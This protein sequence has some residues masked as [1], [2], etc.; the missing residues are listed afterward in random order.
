MTKWTADL[1][2]QVFPLI[3]GIPLPLAQRNRIRQIWTDFFSWADLNE[4]P[5]FNR[6][7]CSKY[8]RNLG[9][10]NKFHF[11]KKWINNLLY[12]ERHK[13]FSLQP[14]NLSD[15]DEN[16]LFP[17]VEEFLISL[18][19]KLAP[20]TIYSYR[21][22]LR[23]FNSFLKEHN[24]DILD[25]NQK[26]IEKYHNES[27]LGEKAIH[28]NHSRIC[29]YLK[30]CHVNNYISEDLTKKLATFKL[31]ERERLPDTYTEE[32]VRTV[33]NSIDRTS[34]K[35]KRDYSII[36][37]VSVYGWRAS[38]IANLRLSH[39]DFDENIIEFRQVKNRLSNKWPIIGVFGNSIVQWLQ[40]RPHSES[41]FIFTPLTNGIRDKE[42]LEPST[43]HTIFA[44]ALR[45]AK[46]K[47]WK[48]KRHGPHSFRFTLAKE[49]FQNDLD[50][51]VIQSIL[52]HVSY[53]TTERYLSI[54]VKHLK[55]CCLEPPVM[56]S[57]F[58]E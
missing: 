54:D 27:A 48:R 21:L 57:D 49:L 23:V 4:F 12:F 10:L 15:R 5:H 16:W 28:M 33:L 14:P 17:N 13:I 53:N 41:D 34:P 55:E 56:E 31:K 46:I 42:K 11:E 6:E 35:G 36:L 38:D 20:S 26:I 29:K 40:C 25:I 1:A 43:I 51:H 50:I 30:F 47:D 18:S 24:L 3:E 52:G 8:L 9:Y 44:N 2:S 19:E 37:A 45:Q 39:F 22:A 7:I 58:Y 32:E